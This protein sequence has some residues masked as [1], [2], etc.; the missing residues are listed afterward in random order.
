MENRE[1]LTQELMSGEKED[2]VK[3]VLD[4]MEVKETKKENLKAQIAEL[5]TLAQRY[6]IPSEFQPGSIVRWKPGLKN[7]K[8]PE[9]NEP[10]IVME[11]LE[12]PI[13]DKS[14][15]TGSAYFNEPL[16]LK[17]GLLVD[18]RLL[19]F[20]YDKNRFEVYPEENSE[21]V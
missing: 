20:Y 2:L 7:K 11:T 9:Y 10:A 6:Q 8:M 16:D 4:L 1:R 21:K 5:R 3:F 13:F 17:L 12:I 14:G 18:N 19:F 15:E